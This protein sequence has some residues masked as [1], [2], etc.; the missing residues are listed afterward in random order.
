MTIAPLEPDRLRHDGTSWLELG[1]QLLERASDRRLPPAERLGLCA[2]VSTLLD[3]FFALRVVR[4]VEPAATGAHGAVVELQAAQDRLWLDELQPALRGHGVDLARIDECDE[5]AR[6]ALATEFDR[7]VHPLLTP[8]AVGPSA[9]FPRVRSLGLG[10]V[11][12]VDRPGR[13]T[14]VCV[15]IP[16]SLP[17]FVRAPGG[18]HVPVEELVVNCLGVLL[19]TDTV[20][21]AAAFRITRAADALHGD[22]EPRRRGFGP[23]TRLELPAGTP[24]ELESKLHE[25]LR[26]P[27]GVTFTTAA[28]LG[29]AALEDLAQAP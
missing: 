16:R 14:F 17:R 29:L 4:L 6:R 9:P 1:A 20:A 15:P 7:W 13:R 8:I 18:I 10:V 27:R 22:L 11:A 26:L 28:P 19:V 5:V 12:L 24:W 23:V 25:S 3:D 2:A 21:F